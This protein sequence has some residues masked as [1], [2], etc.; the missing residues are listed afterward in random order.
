MASLLDPSST[1]EAEVFVFPVSFAQQ[2][3]WFL[4]QL[5]PGNPFYNIPA[6]V[7][8]IG[9]LNIPALEQSF[10]EI[11]RRHE[12]LRTTFRMLEGQ[13]V[14][15][16][17][18]SLHLPLPLV[19]LQELTITEREAAVQ[20]LAQAF[21][22]PFNLA[23]DALLRVK[24]LRLGEAEHV[25]LLTMHHI[26]ADGWSMG[27]LMRELGTH[28]T[29]FSTG[30]PS[31]LADLPIQYADFT[32][33][34]RQWLQGEVLDA[35]LAYWQQQLD[36]A[37]AGLALHT[38]HPRPTLPTFL[39][40]RE[41]IVLPETL[42]K[43]IGC[44]S[45][46]V[47]VTLF[48]TLLA[49]FQTLLYRY[50][51]QEDI[52]VGSPIANRNRSEI[53]GL[54][55]FFANSLVLR[56]DLSGNPT[57]QE[58]LGRVR[59][60]AL[61]AYAHQDLPFEKLVEALQPERDLNRNPL[62]QVVFALQNTPIEILK[63]PGLTL[64]PL[65]F[66][67]G[68]ARF[69]LEFQLVCLDTLG[70]VV[71]YSTD[72]FEQNTIARLLKHFQTLLE[73]I[74]A[75]PEQRIANL[76]LLTADEQYQLL[77]EWN[78][79]QID[80]PKQCI[81]QLFESQV[82][83]APDA[84]AVVCVDKQLTYQELNNHSN[85]L[86]HYLRQ[87]GVGPEVL[88]GICLE[89][90]WQMIMAVLGV[91]KAGGAYVPLDP[92]HPQERLSFILEDANVSV[93]LT[94][95]HLV[96][97]FPNRKLVCLDQD[98]QDITHHQQNL[99]AI[100]TLDNLA[101]VIYTSGSTGKPKGV[102]VQHQGLCNLAAAQRQVFEL[103]ARRGKPLAASQNRILQFASLCFDASVFE[104]VM[105][106]GIGATLCLARE[107][108]LKSPT[109]LL[110][111]LQDWQITTITLPPTVLSV[112][113]A[114]DLPT[115]HT[116]ITAGEACSTNIAHKWARGR[117]FFNAY[118]PTEASIW[119]TTEEFNHDGQLTIGRPIANT[120]VYVLDG[121]LQPVPIG[122]V[123][124]LYISGDGVARG[125]LNNP[126][127]TAECFIPHPFAGEGQGARLYKT[128]D[129]VRYRFDGKLEFFGRVDE[130]VKLRGLR[131]ELTEIETVLAKHP[132]V[133]KSVVI[134][135]ED[136]PGDKRL[137]A[138]LVTKPKSVVTLYE[139]RYF[140]KQKLP[141]Y[142]IPS[143]FVVLKALPLTPNGK[144]D[145][146]ALPIPSQ[147]GTEID[148]HF[149]LQSDETAYVA[150]RT[151]TEQTLVKIWCQLLNLEQIGIHDNFFALGGDSL[152]AMRLIEQIYRECD[153][154]LPLSTLFLA[155]TIESLAR[156][157]QLDGLSWSPLVPIQPSGSNPPFFCVHPI[158][159]LVFPYYELAHHLGYEQP[160]Y[161]LQ[162]LGID[163]VQPP[164]TSI[165]DMARNYIEALRLVQ[166]QGPYF[167]G[168]WS[169]G[170]LV[171]FEMAQ[172]LHRA[173]QPIALLALLDTP[174]P[175]AANQPSWYDGCKFL[176]NTVLRSVWSYI[177]DYFYLQ[178]VA[179]P[180]HSASASASK[181]MQ[182][183]WHNTT[184]RSMLR[185]LR[186]SSQAA[187]R[188]KPEPYPNSIAL[189][190]IS[191]QSSRAHR[192]PT[193]GWS[194]LAV[195][196]VEVHEVPGNHLTML[197]PPHVQLLVK[198]L[199]ECLVQHS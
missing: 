62:F 48:M 76:P 16:I 50:T 167:L 1:T 52:L 138:Y 172:Q 29:V 106:L 140:V 2:R 118:G 108:S 84:V 125:Y 57:F 13:V 111:L 196:G 63:L 30:Q 185:L 150:P 168:G 117:R 177:F 92:N 12:V 101:Y 33:W 23:Q 26:V 110:Q 89:R 97:K 176:L 31:P 80:Y 192:N 148:N 145:R 28:Y 61:G 69:D 126:E 153:R 139:L 169:F 175:V 128:G 124:E 6:A 135:R 119:S 137:V 122:V 120:K 56:T 121:Q 59:E 40:A 70:I 152:I 165:E 49:A 186:A 42:S 75:Q 65:D 134:V 179:K 162:P 90:S 143:A 181:P 146:R 133:Q 173:N 43:Q 78:S 191:N 105:A 149:K 37:P 144:V 67:P 5:V 3:L 141:E 193:M 104:I 199:R 64:S 45:D 159:G 123:G 36:G 163:G 164:H 38:D 98:W 58:L 129:L 34:Q 88:V 9:V 170:G 102:L 156:H 131:I 82:E 77:L 189:F 184:I 32:E 158:L 72:L 174:A 54:I 115:L 14:Q 113:P 180:N 155:P 116:I 136:L 83:Q 183:P 188:Y 87:L 60:V 96:S 53:E 197:R 20:Q 22:Q 86:A 39:G 19:D 46:R 79:T 157:L 47:G 35:Q 147:F 99:P 100:A 160:F 182:L 68:T 7:R 4:D 8:L 142:M 85:Q 187:L 71:T 55:G 27:V 95:Q 74:V 154:D 17:A 195:K 11:V 178:S 130:Q 15:I 194:E 73:G 66:D 151:P 10:N 91:L 81:H 114:A 94:Q 112:L 166:P 41:Y 18:P 25:L 103:R 51:G 24:L 132:A 190:R 127:L 198:K 161:G 107:E 44:L 109:S 21:Q 93:L 171:A